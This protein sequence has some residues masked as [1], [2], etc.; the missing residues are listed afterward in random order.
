MLIVWCFRWTEEILLGELTYQNGWS[1]NIK[2]LFY[3]D[4][5][6]SCGDKMVIRSSY[7]QNRN[8]Y[9]S[10]MISLYWIRAQTSTGTPCWPVIVMVPGGGS[11]G[12][13]GCIVQ[14]S[15][16]CK[17]LP[18]TQSYFMSY[19]HE[20]QKSYQKVSSPNLSALANTSSDVTY[21]LTDWH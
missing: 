8:S 9:T 18:V 4:K 2:M 20:S 17:L 5:K 3:Q 14:F 7:L 19:K 6:S 10:Y 1:F 13:D 16:L 12:N 15:Q 21:F 11:D